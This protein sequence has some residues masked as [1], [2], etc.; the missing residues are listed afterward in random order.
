MPSC[1]HLV[2]EA[3]RRFPYLR[4]RRPPPLAELEA[5]RHRAREGARSV[6]A[7]SVQLS[8][9]ICAITTFGPSS[10]RSVRTAPHAVFLVLARE[11]RIRMHRLE[12]DAVRGRVDRALRAG[13][14]LIRMIWIHVRR[15][16]VLLIPV[17]HNQSA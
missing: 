6:A 16:S 7:K 14:G 10:G 13:C 15:N 5:R 8:L 1:I 4:P 11:S 9:S 3:R 12:E 2:F 17:L